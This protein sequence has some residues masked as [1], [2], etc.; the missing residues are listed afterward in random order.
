MGKVNINGTIMDDEQPKTTGI[1]EPTTA[2]LPNEGY[3][4]SR[5]NNQS[6]TST[7][8]SGRLQQMFNDIGK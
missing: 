4:K 5:S 3:T 6:P 1:Q 7:V 8:D 2:M